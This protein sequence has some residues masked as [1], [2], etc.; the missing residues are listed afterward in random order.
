MIDYAALYKQMHKD[1]NVFGGDSTKI[2]AKQISELVTKFNV[3]SILDYGCGKGLQYTRDRIHHE[4]FN[5]IMPELFDIGVSDYEHLPSGTFDAVISIDVLEHI[6]EI[7]LE[8]VLKQIYSKA[9]KCV[10]L[11][12]H[13]HKAKKYL[14]NGDNVHCTIHP[15]EW[16]IKL[17][18]QYATVHTVIMENSNIEQ[19]IIKNE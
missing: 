11:G 10:F 18:S 7:Q 15:V 9:T 16:W 4:Y 17:A 19:W 6:P 3:S 13:S 5:S 8:D 2:Y 14:P 1:P 12:I